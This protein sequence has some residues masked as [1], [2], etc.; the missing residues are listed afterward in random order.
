M[1]QPKLGDSIDTLTAFASHEIVEAISDPDARSGWNDRTAVNGEISDL[2]GNDDT[3]TLPSGT[4]L[5]AEWWSNFWGSCRLDRQA[6]CPGPSHP[7][8]LLPGECLHLN[9]SIRSADG[10]YA[11]TLRSDGMVVLQGPKHITWAL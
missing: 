9:Q 5:V 10:R 2:C 6:L 1:V 11:L 7:F 4:F 8:G 3:I